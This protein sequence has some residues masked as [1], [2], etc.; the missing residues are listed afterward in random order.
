MKNILDKWTGEVVGTMHIYRISSKRLAERMGVTNRY[1]S[2]ILNC[3]KKP[4]DC[5]SRVRQALNELIQES[6]N[7]FAEAEMY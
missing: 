6:G 2:A 5:K 7:D 4:K 1:L 3:K